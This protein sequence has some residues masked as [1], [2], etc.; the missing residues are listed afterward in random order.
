MRTRLLVTGFG[1]FPTMPRNPSAALA[2]RVAASPRW[3]LHRIDAR[4]HILTTA[5]AAI[6]GEL[7]PA[8]DEGADALLM[9]GVAGRARR[10]RIE[11]RATS[12]RSLLFPDAS[13]ERPDLPTAPRVE[14]ARRTMLAGPTALDLLVRRGVGCCLSRDAGR[15]L[16]NASYFHALGRMPSAIFI[17]IP[18]PSPVRPG[19]RRGGLNQEGRLAAALVDL[20]LVLIR[21]G[22]RE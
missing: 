3:A 18:K 15:Y 5:Y 7:A 6:G 4:C 2:E 19:P 21:E 22:R 13:G 17:H 20:G 9:I 14:A 8:L 1:P 10:V 12:R 11:T 16:C